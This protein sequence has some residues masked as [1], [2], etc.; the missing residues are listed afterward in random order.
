MRMNI[1]LCICKIFKYWGKTGTREI[2]RNLISQF[3]P[4]FYWE[5]KGKKEFLEISTNF[6]S[7]TGFTLRLNTY[8]MCTQWVIFTLVLNWSLVFIYVL[9]F[10]THYFYHPLTLFI[11]LN[12]IFIT[13]YKYNS[14]LPS[15]LTHPL[16]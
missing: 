10:I 11:Y 1:C 8:F 2:C 5:F 13:H 16:P 3:V 14:P 15:L 9:I 7:C 6:S 4:C 12:L